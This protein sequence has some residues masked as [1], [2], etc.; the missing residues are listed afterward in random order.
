MEM[1]PA[2][3]FGRP[4]PQQDGFFHGG[5]SLPPVV[6]CSDCVGNFKTA[7]EGVEP[8]PMWCE[9]RLNRKNPTALFGKRLGFDKY[10]QM[11][12][13]KQPGNRGVSYIQAEIAAIRS[14]VKAG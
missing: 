4:R 12:V 1:A 5:E 14:G 11:P 13:A 7:I 6:S 9:M 8:A 2:A 3:D 10:L